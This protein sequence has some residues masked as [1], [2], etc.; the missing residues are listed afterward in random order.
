MVSH[1]K[2]F[3]DA[4]TR[5]DSDSLNEACSTLEN[6]MKEDCNFENHLWHH[7]FKNQFLIYSSFFLG[8]SLPDLVEIYGKVK[9]NGVFISDNHIDNCG[10][11]I[12]LGLSVF[13][14]S[15]T[16]NVNLVFKG[17]NVNVRTLEKGMNWVYTNDE[18]NIPNY[19]Q[20]YYIF[21]VIS[22]LVKDNKQKYLEKIERV[23]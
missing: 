16:P 15:C 19:F 17:P 9:I 13:D 4:D 18:V 5:G 12:Y 23:K 6:I 22:M 8:P 20:S 7:K 10:F 3:I 1:T 14:H 21:I 2:E 11:G